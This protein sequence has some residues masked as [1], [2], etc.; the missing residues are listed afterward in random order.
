[1]NGNDVE[2]MG[3]NGGVMGDA[4]GVMESILGLLVSRRE[5]EQR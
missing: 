3:K 2:I 1:M 4:Q 5:V